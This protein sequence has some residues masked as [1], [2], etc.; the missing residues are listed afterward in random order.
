MGSLLL[1]FLV[2]L[3]MLIGAV[4]ALMLGTQPTLLGISPGS[5]EQELA[6]WL[7]AGLCT[8]VALVLAS[9]LLLG[10]STGRMRYKQ[11]T[12][13]EVS[14]EP[15]AVETEVLE[16]QQRF[17]QLQDQL[18]DRLGVLWRDKA[19]ILLVVGEQAEIEAIAPGLAE[20]GWLE[21][22]GDVLLWGGPLLGKPSIRCWRAFKAWRPARPL[23]GI[24]WAL[25][26]AQRDNAVGLGAGAFRLRALARQLRWQ[27]PLYLWQVC[28]SDCGQPERILQPVGCLLPAKVSTE[29]LESSL[30]QL[31]T[32][33][34]QQGMGQMADSPA[35]DFLLRL[36]RDLEHN[37][38]AQWRAALAYLLPHTAHGMPL[39]GLVFG[40]PQTATV[41]PGMKN[42]WWPKADWDAVRGDRQAPGRLLGWSWARGVRVSM[43]GMAA[44]VALA[45]LVSFVGNRSQVASA[46]EAL[47]T[48]QQGGPVED[49]ITALDALTRQIERLA[50]R[51]ARG[52]PW[53]LR[54][55]MSQNDSL[56]ASLWA[57]YAE[58]NSRLMRDA[59]TRKLEAELRAFAALPAG[60]ANRAERTLLAHR[61][62]KAYLMMAHPERVDAE[63]LTTVLTTTPAERPE[64]STQ[65]WQDLSPA[66]WRFYA[67]HLQAHPDW[68]I[69]PDADVIA[70]TRQVLLAQ[71]GLRGGLD[72]LYQQVLDEAKN[73]YVD[74]SLHSMVGETDATVL[75]DTSNSVPGVFTRQA[76]EGS[77]R[78]SIDTM[79]ATRR[80]EIDWVLSDNQ[81]GIAS[82]LQPH[83]LKAQLTERY[84]QQ[85]GE[86][87]L[88]FIKSVRW[89]RGQGLDDSIAQLTLMVDKRQSPL[90]ALLNTLSYQGE[91]GNDH[92]AMAQTLSS[93]FENVPG[94]S[95]VALLKHLA[96]VEAGPLDAA[97][98]PIQTL[99][100]KRKS[101]PGTERGQP[102]L[103]VYL[104]GVERARLKLMQLATAPDPSRMAHTTGQAILKGHTLAEADARDYGNLIAKSLGSQYGQFGQNLFVLPLGH[105]WAAVL[106][107]SARRL[108]QQWQQ[109]VVAHWNREFDG[110]YPFAKEGADASLPM[111][112]RMVRAD[113]GI[114][115][116]FVR[117]QLGGMLRK[118]GRRWVA[119]SS[120]QGLQFDPAF[121]KALDQLGELA[122]QLYTDGSMRM[123]FQLQAK[124]VRDVVATS[125][126]LD[127]NRLEYFNQMESWH[128]FH[129]PSGNDHPGA[130]LIWS[131]V[132]SG[133]RLF[134]DY[135]GAWGVIRLLEQGQVTALDDGGRL[136]RLV[137][138]A[139]DGLPLTW[140]MRS[141]TANGPL[142][143]LRLRGFQMPTTVFQVSAAP[144][145]DY[146]MKN[147]Y[148]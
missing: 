27:A 111:L 24:V 46:H 135:Q 96:A 22:D 40:L 144:G 83:V 100:G 28:H 19:R 37:G 69:K 68:Q 84:F 17:A 147:R 124:P 140:H 72:T 115:D 23:D 74:L 131:S 67:E 61:Q 13:E 70:Q 65:R 45:M 109:Q 136:S 16:E 93:H 36:S 79:A 82:E 57:P 117:D 32:P 108:N 87:W 20:A 94:Q 60:S 104:N 6:L 145:A 137:I 49:Q 33:L 90:I 143:L 133:A 25:S 113:S 146:A 5:E 34:R 4:S 1:V 52:V 76:W 81:Q 48:L 134:G 80:D 51:Q 78:R 50:K 59:A 118:E 2:L 30:R 121:L 119:T 14:A 10:R 120:N 91:S 98:G 21:A 3:I 62:L 92:D 11:L 15:V 95:R 75:F 99:L 112:G 101:P 107:P 125:L 9:Y 7:V 73:Q 126:I 89:R 103:Q 63:L 39:R 38:I 64:A 54:L 71:L 106:Q 85:F 44:L 35:H 47:A 110:R 88:T 127:G 56:L 8:L 58:A 132:K 77:I 53:Y 128:H 141:E 142:S 138:T 43:L 123:R 114:I 12:A 97:F 55:G 139:P 86:A 116:Q 41:V 130:S 29:Q 26:E 129:W 18:R 105:V 66:L 148:D 42:A 31:L 122:D 102:S